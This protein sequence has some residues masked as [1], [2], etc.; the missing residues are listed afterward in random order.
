[1]EKKKFV[2]TGMDRIA[3]LFPHFLYWFFKVKSAELNLIFIFVL[4]YV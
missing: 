3:G 2:M 1:M 4:L